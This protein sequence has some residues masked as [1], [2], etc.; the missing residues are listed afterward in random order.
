MVVNISMV[1]QMLKILNVWELFTVILIFETLM[2]LLTVCVEPSPAE[3]K[4]KSRT[5]ILLIDSSI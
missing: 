3:N 4:G 5:F 2:N 1:K